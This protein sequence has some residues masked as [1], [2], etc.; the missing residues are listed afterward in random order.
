MLEIEKECKLEKPIGQQI[1]T[2]GKKSTATPT[3]T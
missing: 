3:I 1:S 2:I